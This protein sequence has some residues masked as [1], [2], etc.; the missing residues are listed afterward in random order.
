MNFNV[1][2]IKKETSQSDSKRSIH[3]AEIKVRV[4]E[5]HRRRGWGQGVAVAPCKILQGIRSG[6]V[7]VSTYIKR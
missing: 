3:L 4:N 5:N 7:L 1:L 6:Q 2:L